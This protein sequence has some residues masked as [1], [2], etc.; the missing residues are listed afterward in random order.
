MVR[1][2]GS[3][4]YE[5]YSDYLAKLKEGNWHTNHLNCDCLCYS[6]YHGAFS[7]SHCYHKSEFH[8]QPEILSKSQEKIFSNS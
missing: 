4:R 2:H 1:R 7:N 5:S 3:Y 6:D 8:F